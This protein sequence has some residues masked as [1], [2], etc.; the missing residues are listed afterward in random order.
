[1]KRYCLPQLAMIIFF[2]IG[3]TAFQANAQS[4][5]C[6]GTASLD[7]VIEDCTFIDEVK[8]DD[9]YRL[10]PNPAS[11]NITIETT[12]ANQQD[13]VVKL[14]NMLGQTLS[15]NTLSQRLTLDISS[16]PAGVYFVTVESQHKIATKRILIQ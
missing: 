4:V 1:M 8:F 13:A 12:N 15:Q 7:V 6:I 5:S 2:M 11:Q 9:A 16:Y 3:N 14:V 10:Y